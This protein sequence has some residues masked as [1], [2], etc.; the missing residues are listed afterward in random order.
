MR[1]L[2]IAGIW[3]CPNATG[4]RP[5]PCLATAFTAVDDRRAVVFGG[6]NGKQDC[7]NDV[8]IIDLQVMNWSKLNK[9]E[10]GPWPEERGGHAACCLNYGQ[11]FPQLLVTGGLDRVQQPLAD[12]WILDV[13]RGTWRKIERVI[14]SPRA[15]H[16]LTAF[17]L[18]P[19]LTEVVEFGGS[20]EPWTGSDETQPAKAE[21]NLWQF[22]M[23]LH[24]T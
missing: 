9:S 6:E 3:S 10:D 22:S 12:A 4:E 16:T 20:P 2:S 1:S 23:L 15:G 8:Y 24:Y 13:D 14:L 11:R 17:S 21:T 5:R 18:G 7:M 19:T